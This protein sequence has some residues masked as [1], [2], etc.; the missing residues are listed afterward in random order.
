MVIDPIDFTVEYKKDI[1]SNS[2]ETYNTD[3]YEIINYRFT[4]NKI[5]IENEKHTVIVEGL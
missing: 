4:N 2:S 3:I 5:K 1:P